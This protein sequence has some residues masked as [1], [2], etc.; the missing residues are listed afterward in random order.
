MFLDNRQLQPYEAKIIYFFNQI[1]GSHMKAGMLTVSAKSVCMCVYVCV[2]VC[3]CM[4]AHVCVCVCA[5][6]CV[7]VCVCSEVINN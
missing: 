4:R 3:V 6:V 7:R 5:C 2:C 1:C